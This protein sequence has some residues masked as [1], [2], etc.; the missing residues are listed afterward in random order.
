MD[1]A[2]AFTVAYVVVG[3]LLILMSLSQSY[4]A[5]LP[6]SSAML[7][8][9]VGLGMGPLGL[10]LLRLDAL[11]DSV[12]LERLTEAAVIVSL[13]ISGMKLDLP[14][15]DRR[16]RVPLLLASVSMLVSVAA[17]AVVGVFLLHLPWGLAILL[18]AILAPTDPVLAS[19]VQLS[20]AGDRDRLRFGLT[21]EGGLNG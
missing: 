18:G 4:I 16:W 13:F 19:D 17:V 5:R 20:N 1:S 10:D 14:L 6:L 11:E 21:G 15:T 3:T 9:L 2:L 12:L 8:L 7:Y